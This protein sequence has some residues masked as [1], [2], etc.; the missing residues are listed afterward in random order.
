LDVPPAS[1][2]FP[3]SRWQA[4]DIWRGQHLVR[5]PP[6]L[7][8][9]DYD[10]SVSLGAGTA[11]LGRLSV[12]APD[13][14]YAAPE[15]ATDSGAMFGGFAELAGYTLEPASAVPGQPLAVRLVWL[16]RA[17]SSAGYLAFLHLSDAEGRVWA[18][19]DA[20]PAEWTRPTPGWLAGEYVVDDRILYLP[21]DLPPGEYALTAGMADQATGERAAA[22]G[23]GALADGRAE[24]TVLP[25]LP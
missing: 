22:S 15:F 9:G 11:E 5:L 4:G 1:A 12:T 20:V 17:T 18:Q 7:P 3:T 24:L 23:P 8:T 19:S 16:A 21:A 6:D 2:S 10:W 25:V 13:R 14:I